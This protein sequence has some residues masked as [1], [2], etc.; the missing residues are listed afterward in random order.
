MSEKLTNGREGVFV[1]L[2][3]VAEDPERLS[4]TEFE[5]FTFLF[6]GL[7]CWRLWEINAVIL[8]CRWGFASTI[9]L[10]LGL[11]LGRTTWDVSIWWHGEGNEEV[12]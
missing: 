7:E 11:L 8:Q 6:L 4:K 2:P 1:R 9:A 5:K 10:V 12:I 3:E